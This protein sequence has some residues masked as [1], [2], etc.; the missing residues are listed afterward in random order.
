MCDTFAASAAC[1][2]GGVSIFAK[3]S[4]REPDEAQVIVSLP[5]REYAKGQSLRCTY[6]EIPQARSTYAVVLS[7]PFWIWGAEMGVNEKGVVI[8]NE[9]LFTRVKP[10]KTPG[11]IGMD[12]LRLGLERADTAEGAA[13]T[14]IELLQRHG[15]AGPCG[16]RD[17]KFQ[18][19]NSYLM[20]DPHEIIVL[21]TVGRNYALKHCTGY[22]S[23]SNG[24][25]LG[26]DWDESSLAQG[27][28]IGRLGDP[29]ITYF[30][31]SLARRRKN[32]DCLIR[33]TGNLTVQDAFGMLRSHNRAHPFAGFNQDVCMHA[34]DPLIRKSQTT[35]SMVV[36][37]NNS[38][39]FKIFVTAGSS[40]CMTSFKPVLPA[41]M[42]EY[43][44]SAGP[45]YDS[46][47][48][49][50]RHEAFHI[51][52]VLRYKR[53]C[54]TLAEEVR[55][56]DDEFCTGLPFYEWSERDESL[57]SRSHEAFSRSSMLDEKWM[58]EMKG[59]KRDRNPLHNSFWKRIARRGG[60]PLV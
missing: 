17:K 50:W 23:I 21:E 32:I 53:I 28:D 26:S 29:L 25:T 2:S 31:G 14:I 22:A 46:E 13:R 60:V 49:W 52:A 56:L 55:R 57:C 19:M 43:I 33:E 37:L 3:N 40:P 39:Q 18:Y 20:M 38:G 5:G 41:C 58:Q 15:Q 44:G 24:I 30:A 34:A 12:L 42:P 1:T 54:S 47:S 9:A 4:D 51:N 7:K 10:E 27:T 36:S 48:Y 59:I 45:R 8:G 35:G 16:Y 11:L 6:I